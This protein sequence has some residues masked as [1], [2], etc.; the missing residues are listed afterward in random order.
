[1]KQET[2]E[3]RE[4]GKVRSKFWAE[5]ALPHKLARVVLR[6]VLDECRASRVTIE[7][8]EEPKI[9]EVVKEATI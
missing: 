4:L 7:R 1:M 5:N 3:R 8:T 2:I 6:Q 9:V